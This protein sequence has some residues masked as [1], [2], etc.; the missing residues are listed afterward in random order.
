MEKKE[1]EEKEKIPHVCESIGHRPLRGRCPKVMIRTHIVLSIS[2]SSDCT[3]PT[4]DLVCISEDLELEGRPS[5]I[6]W[7]DTLDNRRIAIIGTF[8]MV[9]QLS[10]MLGLFQNLSWIPNNCFIETI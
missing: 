7:W 5:A 9:D 10:M 1:E 6:C 8:M 2:A 3:W 4:D